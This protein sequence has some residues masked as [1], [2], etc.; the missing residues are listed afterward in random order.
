MITTGYLTHPTLAPDSAAYATPPHLSLESPSTE[1]AST[2]PTTLYP[3]SNLGLDIAARR[4]LSLW[5]NT[6]S[7]IITLAISSTKLIVALFISVA[8]ILYS[9]LV[10]SLATTSRKA[11]VPIVTK[12]VASMS[13]IAAAT[14]AQATLGISPKLKLELRPN[15]ERGHADH[16]WLKT[17]HTFS[18][19]DYWDPKYQQFGALRVINEDRVEK[20]QGFGTHSHREMEIFSYIVSGEL[21][22]K[23]SMGNL[24]IMKRGDVQMTSAGTGITHSEYN[25]N[26]KEQVHFLQIWVQPHTSRLVPKY[27]T[28][29]FTDA[30][31]T[32]TLVEIVAPIEDEGISNEREGSGPTPIHSSVHLRASI[33]STGKSVT[34]KF[35][36]TKGYVHLIQTS[37]YNTGESSGNKIRIN[38]QLELGE[39]DGSFI[40]G[41]K[42]QEVKIENVGS[43]KAEL[44]V[45]DIQ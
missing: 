30:E 19:A 15:P 20:S 9:P 12:A 40:H 17:F 35:Q 2:Y 1:L 8:A 38:G 29:H 43:G 27:F 32:D 42:A 7:T 5:T 26:T 33:L 41:A 16:G 36:G 28:R 14:P 22:H 25:R 3:R 24:E 10:R 44:L 39:G 18:F 34:H 13:T 37:G 6:S 45:F 31:K 23:D 4:T 11:S 21:E